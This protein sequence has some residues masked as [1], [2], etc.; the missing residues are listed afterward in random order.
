MRGNG[1]RL[2]PPHR[3]ITNSWRS[4][5]N[6]NSRHALISPEPNFRDPIGAKLCWGYFGASKIN[7][8]WK[9]ACLPRRIKSVGGTGLVLT[10]KITANIGPC[11][12]L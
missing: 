12:R 3:V 2:G 5:P 8:T 9:H 7:L 10:N 6:H 4:F 1:A 11:D